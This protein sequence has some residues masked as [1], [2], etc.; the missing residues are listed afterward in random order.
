MGFLGRIGTG[1]KGIF[2][3]GK[4]AKPNIKPSEA[5]PKKVEHSKIR[6]KS[7]G[8]AKKRGILG[9]YEARIRKRG[10]VF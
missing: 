3:D 1:I 2:G 7:R 6:P 10:L 5:K 8:K 9:V 4:G